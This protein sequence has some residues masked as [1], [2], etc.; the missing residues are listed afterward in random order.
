MEDGNLIDKIETP[1]TGREVFDDC[2]LARG[3]LTDWR[4]N[5]ATFPWFSRIGNDGRVV[6]FYDR[7]IC[8]ARKSKLREIPGKAN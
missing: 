6:Y 3:F 4:K 8:R 5:D 2:G 7:D 1:L